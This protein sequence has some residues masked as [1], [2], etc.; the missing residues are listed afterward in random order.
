MNPSTQPA[1][2]GKE[3]TRAR[4]VGRKHRRDRDGLPSQAHPSRVGQGGLLEALTTSPPSRTELH[5]LYELQQERGGGQHLLSTL[6][7]AVAAK[8]VHRCSGKDSAK[9]FV[10]WR[11][12]LHHHFAMNGIHNAA[13]QGWLALGTLEDKAKQWWLSQKSLRPQLVLA[14]DQLV[15]WLRHEMVPSSVTTS[16]LQEW[17]DLKYE[18]NLEDYFQKVAMLDAYHPIDSKDALVMASRP[19]GAALLQKLRAVD[20]AQNYQGINPSQWRD[21]VRNHVLEEESKPTFRAWA[22]LNPKPRHHQPKLRSARSSLA[23]EPATPEEETLSPHSAGDSDEET[24]TDEQW[25]VALSFGTVTNGGRVMKIGQGTAPC[26]VCGKSGH[27]WVQCPHRHREGQC[28]V[29]GSANHAT[30]MCFKR[31]QPDPALF[32]TAGNNGTRPLA[33]PSGNGPSKAP[34][35]AP[36]PGDRPQNPSTAAPQYLRPAPSAVRN[37]SRPSGGSNVRGGAST[38]AT[39]GQQRT[40]PRPNDEPRQKAQPTLRGSRLEQEDP[41]GP[42]DPIENGCEAPSLCEATVTTTEL[43]DKEECPTFK[44]SSTIRKR[45]TGLTQGPALFQACVR[46]V[47]APNA[48]GWVRTRLEEQESRRKVGKPIYPL[49]DPKETGQLFYPVHIQGHAVKMLYDTGASHCFLDAEWARQV[50]LTIRRVSGKATLHHFGGSAENAVQGVCHVD[51]LVLAGRRYAWKF[52]AISPA[53]APVVLGLSFI[54]VHQPKIDLRSFALWT[55]EPSAGATL[56]AIQGNGECERIDDTSIEDFNPVFTPLTTILTAHAI[57]PNS[58]L[59]RHQHA[60]LIQDQQLHL[61]SVTAATTKEEDA[62]QQV[63]NEMTPG[64][65]ALTEKYHS[66]FDPPDKEPPPRTTKHHIKLLAG[67]APTKRRPYPLPPKKLEAMREQIKELAQHGWIEPSVSPW[68]A[69]I[70]FVPKKSGELR[71]CVDFRDLN[72]VTEDDSFP[73]PRIEVMLHRAASA[74]IFSKLDLASGFHQ[75]EVDGESRPLTAFRL[76]EAV[77]G[78]SLWQWKVMPFGLRNAPPTFQRA[79]S[80]TLAGLDHCAIVYIDDILVYSNS[81]S[82]HLQHL[83]AVFSALAAERYHMRL[84]KCEFMKTEVEFLGHRLTPEG[85]QTQLEKVEAVKKWPVPFTTAK[86]AKSFLGVAVWY[87]VFIPHFSTLA[88]PLYELTSTRKKF[89]WTEECAQSVNA[90]KQALSEAPVLARWERDLPTRIITDASK[91][92]LG[93]A[94]EQQHGELWRPV[95]FWSRKLKDA[96]TR[97]SATDLEWMAV[98]QPVTRYGTGC[99]RDN[100]SPYSRITRLWRPSCTKAATT[101]L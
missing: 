94:L 43:P 101:P 87:R 36:K 86:Q 90:L 62:L 85:I 1:P 7:K 53:P 18:G 52:L 14:F 69:P 26:F 49:H 98:V 72:A 99:W 16:S 30:R 10:D 97:Y 89:V 22:N 77:E 29:C 76:P 51:R 81:E 19:F 5:Q 13:T 91:V 58:E 78:S 55:T 65:R 42:L 59:F 73:L 60:P 93:A 11:N 75:I 24:M 70:L 74:T 9:D 88:A 28:G 15:E 6:T 46:R 95:A 41:S 12:A 61:F 68:G 67:A 4:H 31:Y 96:E 100:S 39:T 37:E 56:C 82:E 66:V 64:L 33:G 2:E 25:N 40:N 79:M 54:I 45:S 23:H 21:L 38:P 92:G 27:S 8:T 47:A 63:Y 57:T 84:N 3:G 50:G 20:A 35:V 80:I 17:M 44:I 48:P 34:G 71:L 32:K 83:E